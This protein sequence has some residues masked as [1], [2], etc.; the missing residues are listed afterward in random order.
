M[1]VLNPLILS[2]QTLITASNEP[3]VL[4]EQINAA[5]EKDNLR[6]AIDD[7]QAVIAYYES[8]GREQELPEKYFGMAL[9]LA[10]NGHYTESIKFHK[11]A[12]RM[13]RKFSPYHPTEIFINLGLT[14]EL[15][16]KYR[17]AK[18]W[19]NSKNV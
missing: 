5:L 19:L 15:A 14:Y 4:Y 6:Q 13:H 1:F 8:Q 16:G 7:F 9:V 18:K 12:I 2:A 10:L 11:K 17:K 3:G